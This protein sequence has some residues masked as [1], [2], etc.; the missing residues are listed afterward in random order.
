MRGIFS[1]LVIF[2]LHAKGGGEK[3]GKGGKRTESVSSKGKLPA[4]QAH[5]TRRMRISG[6]RDTHKRRKALLARVAL[7]PPASQCARRL[8]RDI[9]RL[10]FIA[11]RRRTDSIRRRRRRRT[12]HG[13][14][15][16]I[17]ASFSTGE[18]SPSRRRDIIST[19]L[20]SIRSPRR[21]ET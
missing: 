11:L 4:V 8:K 3:R 10:C 7:E 1:G 6:L 18:V 12:Q 17:S 15:I 13:R 2:A 20:L 5:N 14:A 9:P 16:P 19:M 21:V